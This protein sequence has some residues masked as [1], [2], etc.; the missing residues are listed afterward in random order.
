MLIAKREIEKRLAAHPCVPRADSLNTS[1]TFQPR[2][3]DHVLFKLEM[4][5][6]THSF[7]VRGAFSALTQL[8]ANRRSAA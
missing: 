7:K 2:T 5:Q 1:A 4:L 8:T 6:P 3:R